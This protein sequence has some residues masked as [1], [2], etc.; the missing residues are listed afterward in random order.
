ML[1]AACP[2][3]CVLSCACWAAALLTPRCCAALQ[4]DGGS[5]GRAEHGDGDL[6]Q[7]PLQ[8]GG[9]GVGYFVCVNVFCWATCGSWKPQLASQTITSQQAQIMVDITV[10]LEPFQVLALTALILL[11]TSD[12]RINNSS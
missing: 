12:S 9:L 6:G 1:S 5:S 8:V 10:C 3:G 2:L 7:L 11:S 4:G